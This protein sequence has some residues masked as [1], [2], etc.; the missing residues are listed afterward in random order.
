MNSRAASGPD[1]CVSIEILAH[2]ITNSNY[3]VDLGDER[4]VVR[5]PGNDTH[6]LGIDRSNEVVAGGLAAAIGVGP[7][8]LVT[9]ESTG[10]IVFRFIDGRPVSTEELA[11]EPMLGQFV[12]TL[13]L[14]HHAGTTPT[15][16]NP[17]EVIR[18]HRDVATA[19][20]VEAPFDSTLAFE[21]LARIE[22]VRPFRPDGARSQ[23]PLER[24]LPLR[25]STA[26]RRLGVRGDVRSVL[27]PRQR[28]GQQRLLRRRRDR[29]AAPLRR[30]LERPGHRRRCT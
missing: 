9:D 7:E 17:Y 8:V 11:D 3:V 14:V 15:I 26:H 6:L 30:R 21:V 24:Q 2:G 16:W 5:V 19:R 27:R 29:A 23:R 1:G 13:R 25:R 22:I 18:D 4:V 12:E 28:V 20:G 10:C